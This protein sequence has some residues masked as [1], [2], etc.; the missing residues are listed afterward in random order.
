MTILSL[1]ATSLG[2]FFCFTSALSAEVIIGNTTIKGGQDPT[3]GQ[4]YFRGSLLPPYENID[5]V[6]SLNLPTVQESLMPS[7]RL[8][9]CDWRLPSQSTLWRRLPSTR[10]HSGQL[11]FNGGVSLLLFQTSVHTSPFAH[12]YMQLIFFRVSTSLRIV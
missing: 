6:C 5:E 11:A 10:P 3:T 4:Q 9:R 12:Y 7:H 8:T 1:L 2:I